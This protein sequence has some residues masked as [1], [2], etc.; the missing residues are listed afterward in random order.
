MRLSRRQTLGVI[1]APMIVPSSVFGRNAP[2]NRVTIGAIGAGRI[3]RVHDMKEIHKH[4]DAQ[5]VA[6]CDL[7]A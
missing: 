6:V 3:S 1:A 5:I 2:S 7:D 4:A